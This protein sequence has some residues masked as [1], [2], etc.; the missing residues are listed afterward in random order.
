MLSGSCLHKL[1]SRKKHRIRIFNGDVPY[2]TILGQRGDIVINWEAIG[3]IGEIAGAIGVI[4]TLLFLSVQVRSSTLASEVESKIAASRMYTDFLSVLIQ[5]PEVN[6]VLLR[7]RKDITSLTSEEF[8]RFSNLGLQAF[9]FFS[10]GYFQYSRGTLSESDWHE[11]LAIIQFWLRG[12]GCRQWWEKVGMHM[13]GSEFVAF[14]DYEIR[15][16]DSPPKVT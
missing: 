13:Y 7:G 10:A 14:I 9:S 6:E 2:D 16:L 15:K 12:K 1:D 11:N 4:A 8:H 3:A 5:S